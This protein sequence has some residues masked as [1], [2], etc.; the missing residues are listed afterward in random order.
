MYGEV[1][2]LV[3]GLSLSLAFKE[4]VCGFPTDHD[5][6]A[7]VA[8]RCVNSK[9]PDAQSWE[10]WSY[11]S[12]SVVEAPSTGHGTSS[13]RSEGWGSNPL[14]IHLAQRYHGAG[15]P[16]VVFGEP[17]QQNDKLQVLILDFLCDTILKCSS[18][19]CQTFKL[20]SE[21]S[22]GCSIKFLKH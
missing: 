12:A 13:L 21:R 3:P 14:T 10:F 7:S 22:P 17:L 1:K 5:D 4:M 9:Q 2:S 8:T 6:S 18:L 11:N 16:A 15:L 19:L 20:V